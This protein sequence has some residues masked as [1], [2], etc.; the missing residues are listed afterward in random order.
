MR[1][2]GES[3]GGHVGAGAAAGAAVVAGGGLGFG[4]KSLFASF[5]ALHFA[6]DASAA[7]AFRCTFGDGGVGV[8]VRSSRSHLITHARGGARDRTQCSSV[9]LFNVEA[10]C[11]DDI[12]PHNVEW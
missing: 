4:E 6:R 9:C 8:G 10:G 2:A 5:I 12:T 7:A 1:L 11:E 3:C